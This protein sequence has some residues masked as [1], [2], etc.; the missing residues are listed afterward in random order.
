ML[1]KLKLSTRILFL[2]IVITVCFS[3]MFSWL[4]PKIK[5]SMYT[6][7]YEKTRHLVESAWSV[8]DYYAKQAKTKA[9]TLEHA[10]LKA[11]EAIRNMRYEQKDYFWINDLTPRMVMH[12]I[13]PD[14]DGKDLS[15]NKDPN[16]KKLFVEMV[17]VCKKDGSGFVDYHWPKSGESEPVPKISYVKLLSE[18]N[19]IIGS[20][21]YID[22]VQKQLSQTFYII[23]GAVA[24][25]AVG[26]LI[27]SYL[28]ARSI[29]K[30]I[31][32]IS[33]NLN[34]G[35]EQVASASVQ[36]AQSS[37]QLAEGSTEQ[38]SSIEETSSSIEE[39]S[40]MT[41]QNAE[42]AHQADT[43]MNEA[44]QIV[45]K[46]SESMNLL[47]SAMA[48]ISNASEETSKI[49]KTIDE[50]AFQTNL[51]ALNAAVE[52]ARAGEAGAGFAVVA[53]EVR[54][55]ALRAAN[56]A[57]DTSELI[58]QTVKK[59]NSGSEIVTGTGEAFGEV[60]DSSAKVAELLRDIA[61]ASREQAQGIDQVSTAVTEMDKVTQSNAVSAEESASAAEELNAQAEEMKRMVDDLVGLVEG[62]ENE[63]C[64]GARREH[65]SAMT[66]AKNRLAKN[67]A[68]EPKVR[69]DNSRSLPAPRI[70][71]GGP[72]QEIPLDDGDFK[73]F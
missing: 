12:P 17:K 13:K 65:L 35:A 9:M 27:L 57:R 4:Y 71:G 24:F 58:E 48:D 23:F 47:T 21:I 54:S 45:E 32:R 34:E 69:I 53:D 52:A 22:D 11:K 39:M 14:L 40:S 43:L 1:N 19:W 29:A 67:S 15:N 31:A 7:K 26:G 18:W 68:L 64:D 62:R 70:Q 33:A 72:E 46:A 63:I 73:D 56:A 30:P 6:A 38:A 3:I 55:L 60:A 16:G 41:R 25:I 5:K 44:N 37:Q 28:M 36:V 51:L 61:S 66:I 49:I 42:H 10:Q 50:I 2:G 8:L 20:G 59:I